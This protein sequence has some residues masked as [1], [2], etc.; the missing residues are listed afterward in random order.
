[1]IFHVVGAP[2]EHISR[3]EQNQCAAGLEYPAPV[4]QG[5]RV[6]SMCSRQSEAIMTSNVAGSKCILLPSITCTDSWPCSRASAIALSLTSIP[7]RLRKPLFLRSV[8]STP[9]E[10]PTSR[11][12]ASFGELRQPLHDQL[13]TLQQPPV[14]LSDLV[15]LLLKVDIHS[16]RVW[17]GNTES[18][19]P[20]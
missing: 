14:S 8:S 3:H 4:I 20:V 17:L 18:R 5:N 1:M 19:N 6:C 7:D 2:Q 11:I 15:I 10:Q 9:L 13:T 16:G 12:A